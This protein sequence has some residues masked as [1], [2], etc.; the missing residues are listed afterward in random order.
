MMTEFFF[1]QTN[2]PIVQFI[3][4]VLPIFISTVAV[5]VSGM[6]LIIQRR[7][8]INSIKPAIS[9]DWQNVPSVYQIT[10]ENCGIGPALI[11][12]VNIFAQGTW[13]TSFSEVLDSQYPA[14]LSGTFAA[15][16]L[17]NLIVHDDPE[18]HWLKPGGKMTLIRYDH[19]SKEISEKLYSIVTGCRI[20]IVYS[21]IYKNRFESSEVIAVK[22]GK[23]SYGELE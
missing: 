6:T 10:I 16:D 7:H 1:E 12:A 5:I 13:Y 11:D 22:A 15:S 20:S 9:I 23:V 14:L 4:D 8:N 3:V 18:G 21:D 2:S 17:E 19:Q